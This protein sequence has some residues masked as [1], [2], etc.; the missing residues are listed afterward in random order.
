MKHNLCNLWTILYRNWPDYRLSFEIKNKGKLLSWKED[1][2]LSCLAWMR[3]RKNNQHFK[4][5]FHPS[6]PFVHIFLAITS[7]IEPPYS[8]TVPPELQW[9]SVNTVTNGPKKLPVLTRVF[10]TRKSMVVLAGWPKKVVVIMKWP[11][12]Q[13]GRK[14]GFH[15]ILPF[16]QRFCWQS[17]VKLYDPPMAGPACWIKVFHLSL[18]SY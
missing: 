3:K 15:C 16:S 12:Y 5:L 4:P 7:T 6:H 1:I 18:Y 13:G 8:V 14:A 10:F 2:S 11:Y 9:K 17:L